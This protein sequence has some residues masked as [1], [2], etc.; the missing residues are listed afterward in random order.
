MQLNFMY[1]ILRILDN[2]FKISILA[3][4]QTQKIA[5]VGYLIVMP[6]DIMHSSMGSIAPFL[7][8]EDA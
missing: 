6:E 7:E 3:R 1:L 8:M 5:T 4:F 2:S